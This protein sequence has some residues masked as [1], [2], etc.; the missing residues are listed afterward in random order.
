MYLK[1][2]ING[3]EQIFAFENKT[4]VTI[5]RAPDSDIQLLTE[6]ISRNHLIVTEDR[7]EFF[8]EDL[9][10]T[11]GTFLNDARLNANELTP[12]NSFFP[13][14]LGF[15]VYLYLIDE[16]A[17]E[18]V[19]ANLEKKLTEEEEKKRE[20]LRRLRKE[21]L[22]SER[23]YVPKNKNAPVNLE[24]TGKI[25]R[26]KI[27]VK[28]APPAKKKDNF[29]PKTLAAMGL[30]FALSYGVKE[31]F[32]RN[33]FSEDPAPAKTA[34]ASKPVKVSTPA[35]ASEPRASEPRKKVFGLED[36]KEIITMDKCL[37][38]FEEDLCQ[39][40]AS[41]RKRE[42]YEGFVK[43]ASSLFYVLNY[44]KFLDYYSNKLEYSEQ[45]K[46]EV[47]NSLKKFLGRRFSRQKITQSNYRHEDIDSK[48]ELARKAA[49]ITDF[50]ALELARPIIE[51]SEVEN[52]YIILYKNSSSKELVNFAMFKKE[53][54]ASLAGQ[55]KLR[56]DLKFYWRSGLKFPV[57]KFFESNQAFKL[58]IN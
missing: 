39:K 2:D 37:G 26:K 33:I 21:K 51:N 10:S 6:G 45:E 24:A 34:S 20:E 47:L 25:K 54:L 46:E 41:F 53:A 18:K 27:A 19:M 28:R 57:A 22:E 5:G 43:L 32:F 35:P 55:E 40:L 16:V 11:N 4:S 29:L 1:V 3:E 23:V 52:V 50:V 31:N 42:Y 9:N 15:H 17:P 44:E 14:K 12:F 8:V 30:V 38:P 56:E 49:L 36:A 58:E 13:L 7:G 48:S